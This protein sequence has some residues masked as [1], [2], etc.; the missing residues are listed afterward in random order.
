MV[1]ESTVLVYAES[2]TQVFNVPSV[3]S[4]MDMY[5]LIRHKPEKAWMVTLI[6]SNG[7]G[8]LTSKN[9]I[10]CKDF[11]VFKNDEVAAVKSDSRDVIKLDYIGFHDK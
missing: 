9:I 11:V 5:I 6:C 4:V 8:R 10:Y 2:S 3:T 7:S 1:W